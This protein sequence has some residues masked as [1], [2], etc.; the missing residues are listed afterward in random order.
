MPRR[1][2]GGEAKPINNLSS[3][4]NERRAVIPRWSRRTFVCVRGCVCVCV[5]VCVCGVAVAGAGADEES[6]EGGG[7]GERRDFR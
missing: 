1:R 6:H 5:C 3:N 7:G 4:M 2:V